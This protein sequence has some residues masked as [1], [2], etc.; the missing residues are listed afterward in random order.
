MG[1]HWVSAAILALAVAFGEARSRGTLSFL[2]AVQ[3]PAA[4]KPFSTFNEFYPFYLQEH[5]D[6]MTKRTHYVGT[7]CFLALMVFSK[8][9][10]V[11]PILAA[12]AVGFAAFPMLRHLSSGIPEGALMIGTYLIGGYAATGS[13]RTVF[14]PMICAYGMAWLGHFAFEGNKPATFIYPTFSLLGDFRMFAEM[15]MGKQPR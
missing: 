11:L 13:W 8:G 4:S 3:P 2:P 1:A 15:V 14:L 12:A 7:F 6:I 9:R 10:L 5:S